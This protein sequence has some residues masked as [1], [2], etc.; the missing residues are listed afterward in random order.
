MSRTFSWYK[1]QHK[2][3]CSYEACVKDLQI[4]NT[5]L[6]VG[7]EHLSHKIG[8]EYLAHLLG[9][10]LTVRFCRSGPFGNLPGIKALY[11][12]G[13]EIFPHYSFGGLRL[14]Q[15]SWC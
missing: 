7:I 13:K 1:M 2:G 4:W 12:S 8:S 14:A 6:S 5:M 9:A 11:F 15:L 3:T 10:S